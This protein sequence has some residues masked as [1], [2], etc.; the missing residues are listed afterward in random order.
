M[1]YLRRRKRPRAPRPSKS[2]DDGSGTTMES[3]ANAPI[4]AGLLVPL[5]LP[6]EE[7]ANTSI[8]SPIEKSVT[9]K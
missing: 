7:V 1:F 8:S 9:S 4:V 6:K 5:A 3:K 2:V